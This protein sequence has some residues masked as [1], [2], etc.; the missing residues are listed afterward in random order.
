MDVLNRLYNILQGSVTE[1][2][3][4]AIPSDLERCWVATSYEMRCR[5]LRVYWQER[6]ERSRG[7]KMVDYFMGWTRFL[8]LSLKGSEWVINVA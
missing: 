7:L 5:R 6:D 4:K 2:E 3:Y 8:G 1:A